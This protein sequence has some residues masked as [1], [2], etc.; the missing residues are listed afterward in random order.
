MVR[1]ESPG[2]APAAHARASNWR[3]HAVELTDMPPAKAA[4]EGAQGGW[5]LHAAENTDRPTGAQRIGVVDAVAPAKAEASVR[6]CPLARPGCKVMV[7]EFPGR[8]WQKGA[9]RH[10]PPGGGRQRR[11]GCGR[12]CSVAASIGCSLFPG[13]VPKP[14]S[15]IQRS[16]L[17]LLG[18]C[19]SVGGLR[20][21][22]GRGF[23]PS[24]GG[25]LFKRRKTRRVDLRSGG[26][27]RPAWRRLVRTTSRWPRLRDTGRRP[28]PP[29]PGNVQRL[30]GPFRL[31]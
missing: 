18:L 1:G 13:G 10:W 25:R 9:V 17:C 21:W 24:V 7:D 28:Y 2:P 23:L 8:G 12:D 5:R 15:Q 27:V 3:H 31:T 19:P 26:G 6:S 16:T 14:L 30:Q 11:C 4:Q 20:A 22:P 29:P